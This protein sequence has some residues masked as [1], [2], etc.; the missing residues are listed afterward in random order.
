[1]REKW[2]E[3]RWMESHRE[4]APTKSKKVKR[5]KT[6]GRRGKREN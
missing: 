5:R 1:M 6:R 3:G 2:V 4:W